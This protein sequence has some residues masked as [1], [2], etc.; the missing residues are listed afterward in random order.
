MSSAKDES[1][2]I[3]IGVLMA[4]QHGSG[5]VIGLN[6]KFRRLIS[7]KRGKIVRLGMNLKETEQMM[8]ESYKSEFFFIDGC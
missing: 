7:E 3:S 2:N 5:E 8:V 1:F 6:R 4:D